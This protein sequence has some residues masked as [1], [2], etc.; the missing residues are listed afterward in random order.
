MDESVD[1]IKRE[2]LQFGGGLEAQLAGSEAAKILADA[3]RAKLVEY[4]KDLEKY[5]EANAAKYSDVDKFFKDAI[6]EFNKLN[7][8]IL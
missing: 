4:F 1:F 3:K 6:K 7:T 5:I 8:K 2:E